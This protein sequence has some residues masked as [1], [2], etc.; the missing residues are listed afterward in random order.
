MRLQIA[1]TKGKGRARSLTAER[2]ING[3]AVK[4]PEG[5]ESSVATCGV[6]GMVTYAVVGAG[7]IR[8]QIDA[9]GKKYVVS[10][11]ALYSVDASGSV[12]ASLGGIPGVGLVSMATDGERVV[13]VTDPDAYVYTIGSSS[14]GQVTDPNF[15]GAHS[16]VWMNQY[17]V[18]AS[19]TEHFVSAV[20]GLEPF[21]LLL[22]A[23]AEYD[24]DAIIGIARDRSE[25]LIFGEKSLEPWANVQVGL[26]TDYPFEAISGAIVDKGL[27][28]RHAI[29][30]LD[31]STVWLDQHGIVRRLTQ[32][33][34]PTR[35]STE[36]I[37]HA[38]AS[39]TLSA[40]EMLVYVVEGH[41]CFALNTDVGTFVYDASTQLWHERESFG[42]SRWK[43]QTSCF[44]DGRWYVGSSMDGTISY[45]SLDADDENGQPLVYSLRFPPIVNDRKR[46]T[47]NDLE[48]GADVGTGTATVDPIITLFTSRD[49]EVF[50]SAGQRTM[51]KSGERTKRVRWDRLGQYEKCTLR[52]DIADPYR[53]AVYAGYADVTPD[54]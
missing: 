44:A 40:A 35:I 39:A 4:A 2:I 28:G 19:D 24:A 13:V 11:S 16:V 32:G 38:I 42:M 43:A 47:I 17:F 49:G 9:A 14:F 26:A 50:V 37:E 1:L 15:G 8:G 7:P 12:S 41:E 36:A 33:Y 27:A 29:A 23:S 10:G 46:F 20:G 48:I 54:D 6:P 53:R 25:L 21:D 3:Y 34:T 45:L 22:S 5:A 52:V 30:Q 18:F 31:N 51:G